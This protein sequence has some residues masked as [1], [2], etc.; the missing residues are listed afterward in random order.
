M[1]LLPPL[2]PWED[3]AGEEEMA[4]GRLFQPRGLGRL[5][6]FGAE[7]HGCWMFGGCRSEEMM[8]RDMINRRRAIPIDFI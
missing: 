5:E 2:D 1:G 8:D 4:L 3:A 6:L 7:P